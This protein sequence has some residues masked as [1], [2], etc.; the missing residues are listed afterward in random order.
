VPHP[1][2]DADQ[3]FCER[4]DSWK[5]I[6]G[7]LR[8]G[9]RTVQR[10]ERAAGLPVRRV[11]PGRGAVYAFRADLDAWWR[12]QPV[13]LTGES[14]GDRRREHRSIQDIQSDLVQSRDQAPTSPHG[15]MRVRP[16]LSQSMDVNPES[17]AAHAD[18]AVYFFTLVAVGLLRPSEGMPAARAAAQR[19]I[20]LAPSMSHAHAVLA[21]VAALYDYDWREAAR[22]FDVALQGNGAPLVRFHYAAWY[23]SPLGRH[24]SALAQVRRGLVDDPL[25]L[26]GRALVGME[27]CSLGRGREGVHELEQILTI[28]PRFGP[29]LGL[30]GREC[31]LSGRVDDALTLAERAYEAVPQHPMPS[32]SL[33]ACCNG[34]A[35]TNG[36]ASSSIRSS[37]RAP[38]PSHVHGPN[39][40]S[41]SETSTEP[42]NR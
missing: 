14:A 3:E 37:A 31:I 21:I 8:R 10:W 11:A 41:R 6:A 33:R 26:L 5:E 28:D 36:V 30:L 13:H 27:L 35:T 19:G 2:R 24:E 39:S 29:A 15:A 32:D 40:S 12:K 42:S 17:A 16:F 9:L 1:A 25:Y 20:E 7:Y 34:S 18:L 22:R 38:G 23:L 4:L